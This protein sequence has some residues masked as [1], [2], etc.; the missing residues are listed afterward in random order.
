MKFDIITIGGSTEDISIITK[1]GILIKNKKDAFKQELL[2]YE[3]G[4]KIKVHNSFVNFG[5]GAANSAVNFSVQGFR[6]ACIVSIGDD[7]R[8]KRVIE[9]FKKRKVDVSLIKK[10]KNKETGFS[11]ILLN[12]EKIVFSCRG[13]NDEL[14]L[15]KDNLKV[16]NETGFV[17]LTSLGGKWDKVLKD[18]FS[19]NAKIAW[20]PG[21]EQIKKADKIKK[22]LKKTFVF[23]VNKDEAIETVAR[24]T[25]KRIPNKK[26]NNI[27]FLLK[28]IKSYGPEIAVIT[29]GKNGAFAYDGK[30]VYY[31]PIAKEN[32]RVDATGVGDAF[33]STFISS[34]FVSDNIQKAMEAGVKNTAS[35][36]AYSGAQNGLKPV[37][38]SKNKKNNY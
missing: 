28:E 3:Y 25:K 24:N 31:Q 10:V 20:N 13:A 11:F 33:N 38:K 37:V 36:I 30:K 29:D 8:G 17:Y 19:C 9:N 23:F 35:V 15:S 4:A 1:E 7:D 18:L 21:G 2:A 14:K 22:Y 27:D 16:I 32:K 26:I 5:G 34:L 12:P 6:S